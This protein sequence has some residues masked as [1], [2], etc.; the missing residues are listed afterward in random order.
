MVDAVQDKKYVIDFYSLSIT[1]TANVASIAAGLEAIVAG[2]GS[3]SFEVNGYT[4]EIWQP[5]RRSAPLPDSFAGQFRKFRTSDL[6]EIG[7]AG[8]DALELELEANQG[9]VERNFFVYY[10]ARNLLGWCR[11]SHGNT[12]NQFA[13]FLSAL[14]STKVIA[15]PI[16]APDA[17]RRIMRNEISLKKIILTIPRPSNPDMYSDNDF[18]RG[19]MEMMSGSDA[20][21]IHIEMGI[22]SRRSDTRG[23]LAERLKRA[24]TE[25]ASLGASTA[26][27]IVY[28]E[29]IEH[30]IDL[31]ADRV[32]SVQELETNAK[33]PPAGTMY[34]AV[35][36][37]RQ[38]CQGSIDDYFG[39]PDGA[40]D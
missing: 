15:G 22:D 24:L 19:M 5:L 18:T 21:S 6:P 31:I 1:P 9:L 37:A 28:D 30:P 36:T 25:A 12:A 35:D 39:P 4:R 40:V 7:S 34:Q 33:Y 29:G 14:W 17:A 27:A 20:D 3:R 23:S 26:K 32:F 38:E 8:Q 13:K 10:P 16:L 2:P 11:N